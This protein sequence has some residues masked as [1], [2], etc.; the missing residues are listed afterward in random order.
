MA[1]W[2]ANKGDGPEWIVLATLEEAQDVI[3]GFSDV[4][5]VT[6][7]D[8]TEVNVPIEHVSNVFVWDDGIERVLCY[9]RSVQK[10]RYEKT[11]EVKETKRNLMESKAPRR[12]ISHPSENVR[13]SDPFDDEVF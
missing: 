9:P 7:K 2:R 6:R 13:G 12:E 11:H 5:P 8:G 1:S 4:L 10:S 3:E